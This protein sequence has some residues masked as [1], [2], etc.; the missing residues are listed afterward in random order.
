MQSRK[1]RLSEGETGMEREDV[2]SILVYYGNIPGMIEAENQWYKQIE[3]QYYNGLRSPRMDGMP[4]GQTSGSQTES[5]GMLAANAGVSEGREKHFVRLEV[6]HADQD[7]IRGCL[8]ALNGIYKKVIFN[9]YVRGYSWAKISVKMSAP[10]STVRSWHDRA[11]DKLGKLL[12]ED[13]LMLDELTSRAS[14]AR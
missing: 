13:V 9:R 2:K 14:R 7:T 1:T 12:E 6:L 8:D 4:H 10:E 11:V 5:M 3:D